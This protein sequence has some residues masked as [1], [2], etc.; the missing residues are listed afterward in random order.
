MEKLQLIYCAKCKRAIGTGPG[1][2]HRTK[3]G[4]THIGKVLEVNEEMPVVQT[5]TALRP[6]APSGEGTFLEAMT[7]KYRKNFK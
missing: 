6:G 1:G 4:K 5:G 3:D 2:S 7:K